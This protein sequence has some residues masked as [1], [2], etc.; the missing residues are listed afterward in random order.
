MVRDHIY[1]VVSLDDTSRRAVVHQHADCIRVV[2]VALVLLGAERRRSH[3]I[4]GGHGCGF[5]LDEGVFQAFSLVLVA[6][7]EADWGCA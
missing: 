1:T 6:L 7:G 3:L 5:G 2:L 4:L